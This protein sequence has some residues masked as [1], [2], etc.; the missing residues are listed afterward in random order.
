MAADTVHVLVTGVKSRSHLLY[1]ASYV[2]TRLAQRAGLRMLVSVLPSSG[3]L[4]ADT[5][6]LDDVR[7]LL[8]ADARMTV[9][10]D[11]PGW[12]FQDG[13]EAVY[14]SV[15]AP[16]MRALSKIRRADPRRRVHV[17]VTDE[18]IGTYGSFATRRDAMRRQG[19]SAFAASLK[20]G[21]V[22]TSAR[23][24]TSERWPAYVPSA[25]AWSVSEPVAREFGRHLPSDVRPGSSDLAVVLTQPFVDLG[26]VDEGVYLA[27]VET[28]CAAAREAGLRPVVRAH[29]AER[30]DRYDRFEVLPGCGT[31]ELDPDV[32]GASV[33]MGGPSTALV[34]LA[35]MEGGRVLWVSEPSLTALDTDVSKQQ[36]EIFDTFLGPRIPLAAISEY[37]R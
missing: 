19:A 33:V 4:A 34:N 6:G 11:F 5:V 1:V 32:V 17:V 23:L 18:G 15:G 36:R 25:G 9:T 27:Y 14:V 8:P 7:E 13:A 30:R 20:A 21:L 12:R 35:A 22:V 3:F 2:R 28:L 31:A 16:G 26:L 24:F 29:P 37:L 10:D